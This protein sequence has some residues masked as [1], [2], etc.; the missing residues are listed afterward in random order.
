MG[1]G[2]VSVKVLSLGV[3]KRDGEKEKSQ[4]VKTGSINQDE[5]K[6]WLS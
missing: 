1:R 5:D 6:L 4:T 2:D 3:K